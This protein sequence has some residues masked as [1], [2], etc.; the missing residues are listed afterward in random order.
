MAED[1]ED[2][3]TG[4]SVTP[5]L[6][7]RAPWEAMARGG[8][9]K[10]LIAGVKALVASGPADAPGNELGL[11]LETELDNVERSE[12]PFPLGIWPIWLLRLVMEWEGDRAWAWSMPKARL[13]LRRKALPEL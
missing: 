4:C 11:L 9:E 12:E 2:E 6:P 1:V 10:G 5:L 3:E 13:L 8:A 7:S